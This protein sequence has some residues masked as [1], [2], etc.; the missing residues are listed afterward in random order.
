MGIPRR[1]SLIQ[2]WYY[3][4]IPDYQTLMLPVLMASSTG[5]VR[6]GDVVDKLTAKF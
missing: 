5:E 6:I 4:A 2:G 3:M 1:V